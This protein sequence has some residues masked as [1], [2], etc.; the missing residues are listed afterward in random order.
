MIG[1]K[2]GKA[3]K[4]SAAHTASMHVSSKEPLVERIKRRTKKA[5]KWGLI[6]LAAL[7]ARPAVLTAQDIAA[8]FS[9]GAESGQIS[10]ESKKDNMYC[11]FDFGTMA[12]SLTPTKEG[13][14]LNSMGK[15]LFDGIEN[16]KSNVN[17]GDQVIRFFD[18]VTTVDVSEFK[19][20]K[21]DYLA[22]G[23]D[24]KTYRA[25]YLNETLHNYYTT[26]QDNKNIEVYTYVIDESALNLKN[27]NGKIADETYISIKFNDPNNKDKKYISHTVFT[28]EY[29]IKRVMPFLGTVKDNLIEF[30][31]YIS[32]TK[33]GKDYEMI[34]YISYQQGKT[35]VTVYFGRDINTISCFVEQYAML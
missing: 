9:K 10:K 31:V 11:Y 1:E 22:M 28:K 32:Y 35:P 27:K 30:G 21:E 26:F 3:L 23:V 29:K 5:A 17:F 4:D 13:G 20:I 16:G 8:N 2:S 18:G 14:K 34:K 19:S 25:A 6:G 33:D 7:M 15:A 24:A 12:D